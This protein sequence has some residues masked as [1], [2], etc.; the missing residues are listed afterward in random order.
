MKPRYIIIAALLAIASAFV[1]C[2]CAVIDGFRQ[3]DTASY[4][5]TETKR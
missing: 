2:G 1:F 4:N 3:F 5:K